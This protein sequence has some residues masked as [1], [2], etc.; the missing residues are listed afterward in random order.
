MPTPPSGGPDR[1]REGLALTFD[2]VLLIPSRSSVLPA[3]VDLRARFSRSIELNVP[4]VSAAMDTVTES[5]MAIA[6]AQNGGIGVIH[7]NMPPDRQALEVRKVKKH[8]S[9]VVTD[10]VTISSDQ[11]IARARSL[12]EENG[13][14]GLPVVD[15]GSL[16][17]IITNRDLR[18]KKDGSMSVA[19]AMTRDLVTIR[20]NAPMEEAVRLLDR[21]KIEKLLVT[22]GSGRLRGLITVKDI[23]KKKEFPDSCKDREGRLMVAAAVGP[24]DMRRARML[25]DAGADC[26]VIDTAHGHSDNV[27]KGVAAMKE[28]FGVDVA[29][30]NVATAEAAEDLISAGADAIK[31]GIGPGSICTTRVVAGAGVPQITAIQECSA[32]AG[33][34]GVPVIADGGIKYSGDIAKAI[35]AGASS[36]MLGSM[37]AGTQESP[38]RV[39]FVRGRKYKSYRGMGS[40]GAMRDGSDRYAPGERGKFVPE[41]VEGIVPFRGTAGEMLFQMLGGLRSAMGYCGC[42]TLEE[43]RSRP[44][45]LRITK[46]GVRESHPHDITITEEAPNYWA[47]ENSEKAGLGEI[48]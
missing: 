18:F 32:A 16:S 38:G 41:G 30:G 33:R 31:V 40:L 12:M 8:E 44:R 2:D 39:V 26:L 24:L 19:E 34:H 47:S 36:V 10:P 46:A 11:T 37:M 1:M 35:A 5:G 45:F 9:C 14:S 6:M 20:E 17:G 3:D 42:A 13:I 43:M 21:H 29:A 27:L 28:A 23:S 15:G 4:I 25:A 48:R 22:D 7:R